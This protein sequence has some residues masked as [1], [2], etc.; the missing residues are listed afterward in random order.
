M[1]PEA[2]EAIDNG[3]M[4]TPKPRSQQKKVVTKARST[5]LS[6]CQGCNAASR[7]PL[8]ARSQTPA[9]ARP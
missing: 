6:V 7:S 8:A 2:A 5:G 9:P 4:T 3:S 1:V